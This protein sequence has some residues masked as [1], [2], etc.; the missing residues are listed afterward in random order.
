MGS[1][2]TR[3]GLA[4]LL[5]TGVSNAQTIHYN[6]KNKELTM[7]TIQKNKETVRRL[8]EESLNK[9]KMELLNDLISEEFSGPQGSKGVAGFAAPITA[10]IQAF[11]DAQWKIE[12]LLG[13]GDQVAARWSWKGT[14][15]GPFNNIPA[16]GQL[17]SSEG[18]A[19]F[20]L[21]EARIISSHT[22]TDRYGFLQQLEKARP[23]RISLIDKFTVPPA[24]KQEFYERMKINR[25]L[26]SKLPGF[27]EDAVYE[28]TAE[29]GDLVCVTVAQW[30]NQESIN[31]AREAVQATYQREGFDMPAMLKRLHIVMD[32]GIYTSVQSR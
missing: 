22:L 9:K 3:L 23:E 12:A 15:Q 32:R 26:I 29:N 16:S 30:Q 8:F 13:E 14:Q 2:R 18:M 4:L 20:Q 21:R 11:P 6:N 7:S 27:I 10:L 24:A 5:L 19:I 31:K 17:I 28:H 25:D 1:I